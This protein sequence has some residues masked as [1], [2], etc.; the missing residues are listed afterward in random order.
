[1]RRVDYGEIAGFYD[2]RY[3]TN[4]FASVEHVLRDFIGAAR[5]VAE[6]GCGTGHWLEFVAT[7]CQRPFVVGLDRA[8]AMLARAHL[9]APAAGL[10][11]GTADRL[12]WVSA[13]FDRVFAVNA[14]H[15]F[16]DH[17]AVFAECVR[18]VC[19]G[20][21]FMTIGL[22]PHA[23]HDFWWIYDYFP[24]ALVADRL[25]YPSAASIRAKLSSAG[26]EHVET[27]VAQRISARIAFEEAE[28]KGL[29]ER[30]STSQ[31][32][33]IDD[34]DWAAGLARLQLERPTLCADLRLYATIGWRH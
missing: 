7:F 13:A 8:S 19:A 30:N 33:V 32:L 25:R 3:A 4:D 11:R 17:D 29:V 23:G 22:D 27:I 21:A 31:L 24:A 1:M 16:S 12:P 34:A 5:S 2:R 18:V 26:F 9:A 28:T 10:V 14:L 6:L 15:H 20:G